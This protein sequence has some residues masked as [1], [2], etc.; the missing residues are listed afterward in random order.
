M[1]HHVKI[2]MGILLLRMT[3]TSILLEEITDRV[4]FV[5]TKINFGLHIGEDNVL[6]ISPLTLQ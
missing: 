4:V 5:K 1:D 6:I 2:G 3:F